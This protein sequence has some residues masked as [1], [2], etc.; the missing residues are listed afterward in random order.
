[1]NAT[2]VMYLAAIAAAI[3]VLLGAL[4][5]NSLN[6][7]LAKFS[8]PAFPAAA[9]PWLGLALGLGGGF[10]TGL[11][12]GLPWQQSLATAILGMLG[13]GA[14]ALHVES[15]VGNTHAAVKAAKAANDNAGPPPAAVPPPPAKAA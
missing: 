1:M 15:M 9:M 4:Q 11:Q 8:I 6:Q 13:G 14:S 5:S 2:T 7:M 12:Q 3:H 10:V